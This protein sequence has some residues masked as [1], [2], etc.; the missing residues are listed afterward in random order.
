MASCALVVLILALFSSCDKGVEPVRKPREYQWRVTE[1]KQPGVSQLALSSIWGSSPT[2]VFVSGFSSGGGG[3]LF[4]FDGTSWKPV[5]SFGGEFNYFQEIIGFGPGDVWIAGERTYFISPNDPIR[6]SAVVFRY[7]GSTWTQIL[8]SHMGARGL[9][10]I[11]GTSPENMY[12]GSNDGKILRYNGF[13]WSIDTLHTGL[14]SVNTIGGDESL[15]F[16]FG[17][18]WAGNV[19]DTVTWF[20]NRGANWDRKLIQHWSGFSVFPQFGLQSFFSPGPGEYL[21]GTFHAIFRF[22]GSDWDR[23]LSDDGGSFIG[24]HGSRSSNIFAVGRKSGA[25]VYHFDGSAWEQIPSIA[26]L[27]PDNVGLQDVVVF[28]NEVFAVGTNNVT[29]FVL[30]GK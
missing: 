5:A 16:A 3:G 6:D 29:S 25:M 7:N 19:D 30:H 10:S 27:L 26:S 20:I 24:M 15:Q 2:S 18:T 1:L 14:F 21:S 13:Q 17:N 9:Y 22:N 11:W 28:E 4:H 23:V 12:C 8:P